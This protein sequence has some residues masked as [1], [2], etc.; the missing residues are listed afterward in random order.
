MQWSH[1]CRALS[2]ARRFEGVS[3]KYFV[4]GRERQAAA[5]SWRSVAKP[6]L[7]PRDNLPCGS[8]AG[9]STLRE[10]ARLLAGQRQ[11]DTLASNCSKACPRLHDPPPP[12]CSC[13]T[14]STRAAAGGSYSAGSCSQAW[15]PGS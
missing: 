14:S 13:P 11:Q 2:C 15:L 5:V 10:A 1:V 4:G 6:P 9:P 12:L 7:A 8:R 3:G